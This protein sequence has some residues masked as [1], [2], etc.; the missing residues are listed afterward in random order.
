MQIPPRNLL[1]PP[2]SPAACP[3]HFQ[4]A[5]QHEDKDEQNEEDEFTADG[6]GLKEYS[7]VGSSQEDEHEN[8]GYNTPQLRVQVNPAAKRTCEWMTRESSCSQDIARS[9]AQSV[10]STVKDATWCTQTWQGC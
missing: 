10:M 2:T 7:C 9:W 5:V 6:V 4:M 1:I 3:F 8:N